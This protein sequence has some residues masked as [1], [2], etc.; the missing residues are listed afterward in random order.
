MSKELAI[1]PID[2]HGNV[3]ISIIDKI[4]VE[5]KWKK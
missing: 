4:H 3:A 2:F 1:F 5:K